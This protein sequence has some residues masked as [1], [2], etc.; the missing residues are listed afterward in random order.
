MSLDV[1]IVGL[2]NVGKSTLFN[3]LTA[4]GALAANYPF[5]TIEPNVGVVAVPDKRLGRIEK[6]I[7][8]QSVIPAQVRFVDI[9]GLVKGAATGEGLGNKFL[10]NIRETDAVAHVVR[11]FEDEDV[12]HVGGRVDPAGDMETIDT[13]L[14]LADVETATSAL[15]KVA[16][17][18]KSGDKDAAAQ[19]VVL[20]K[21][22][23]P[24]ND[25]KPLRSLDWSDDE[26]R[27]LR[28]F[29]LITLKKVLYVANVDE[30]DPKGEG[31]LA[32]A[33]RKKAAE[34]GSPI[35]PV[36]AKIESELA[37]LDAADRDEMLKDLGLDEPALASLGRAAYALLGLE[38][39]FTAGEKE[40]RAWTIHKGATAPQAAG[41]IHTDFERG[42]IRAEVY[43]LDDLEKYGSELAIK[44]AGRL[45]SEGKG[46]IV[47]DGD[48]MH[49][50]FNV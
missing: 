40:I 26:R 23:G 50:R 19:K 34:D 4:A 27:L 33:A 48:I 7:P 28:G 18:A 29:G 45:R 20:E 38:S 25:A 1:G 36:C 13:E 31:A 22:V 42:F 49:F 15:D 10:A 39:Y 24:L 30:G 17:R 41:V 47:Q 43:S 3:A 12:Q 2:P 11:C 5:A 32:Q 37:E 21:A 8:T 35:V 44:S 14:A 9:A 46:Y 16:R 6:H